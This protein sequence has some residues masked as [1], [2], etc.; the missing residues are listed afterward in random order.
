LKNV[1]WRALRPSET[2]ALSPGTGLARTI[3]SE[4][5]TQMTIDSTMIAS[6]TIAASMIQGMAG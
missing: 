2:G 1:I 3:Q 5:E 4:C 6:A